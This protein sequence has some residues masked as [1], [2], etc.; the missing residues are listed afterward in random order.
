MFLHWLSIRKLNPS[1]STELFT[2]FNLR[3]EISYS[4]LYVINVSPRA[5]SFTG[6]NDFWRWY[7]GLAIMLM[8]RF[9]LSIMPGGALYFAVKNTEFNSLIHC[10]QLEG[11]SRL[12]DNTHEWAWITLAVISKFKIV[13]RQFTGPNSSL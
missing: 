4:W 6:K 8:S 11:F 10:L 7:L 3:N 12:F 1:F 2:S 5:N 9:Q 13:N